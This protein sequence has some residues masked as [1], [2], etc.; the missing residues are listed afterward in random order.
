MIYLLI[1]SFVAIIIA[2]IVAVRPSAQERLIAAIRH[3]A[4]AKGWKIHLNSGDEL[5]WFQPFH[6][7]HQVVCYFQ[8][9]EEPANERVYPE[10]VYCNQGNNG[11]LAKQYLVIPVK[12]ELFEYSNKE[13][14]HK[15]L[16]DSL[17]TQFGEH[18]YG[19]EF[20]RSGFYCYW[21]EKLSK[22]EAISFL[23]A[24]AQFIHNPS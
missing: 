14:P 10:W 19:L 8:Y 6:L 16:A 17:F 7:S 21:D 18:I 4:L 2:S 5:D 9:L 1:A 23:D 24:L 11:V 3:Q 22:A 20:K 15:E 13:L 12:P